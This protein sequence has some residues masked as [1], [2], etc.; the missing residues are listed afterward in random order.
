VFVGCLSVGLQH[1]LAINLYLWFPHS[2]SQCIINIRCVVGEDD[3]E[4]EAGVNGAV[5]T[6]VDLAGAEREKK[7][8]N[9]VSHLMLEPY[10]GYFTYSLGK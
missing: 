1:I 7:T 4:G 6:F 9:Q 5:L 2:R 8:G 3:G 10:N